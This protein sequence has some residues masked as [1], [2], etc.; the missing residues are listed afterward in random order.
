MLGRKK[1]IVTAGAAAVLTIVTVGVGLALD[2]P[3]QA[4]GT[5]N[6]TDASS[7]PGPGSSDSQ[8]IPA[9]DELTG[10]V[11]RTGDDIDDLAVGG[12]DL[13]FGPESWVADAGALEDYDADGSAEALGVELDGLVGTEVRLR[14]HLD[15]DGDDADVYAINELTYR[16]VSGPAPWQSGDAVGEDGIRAA[17]AAVVGDG[18]RVA[19]L[20]AED[21]TTV[22]WE[23]EVIDN[24]GREHD[25]LLDS[26]GNVIDVR[27]D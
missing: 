13:D 26:A 27:P 25:V 14:V 6:L 2:D 1:F 10:V 3:E 5:V 18:A 16:A 19:D 9:L 4:V 8:Q 20:E 23:A 11:D 21:G 12:V 24:Q 15:N 7:Q 17:A 22:A